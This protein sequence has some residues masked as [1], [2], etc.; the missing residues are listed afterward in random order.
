MMTW[1]AV[2][3]SGWDWD[4]ADGEAVIIEA[5]T[6]EGAA[7]NALQNGMAGDADGGDLKVAV[8]DLVGFVDFDR[9]DGAIAVGEF[10][11]INNTFD[12]SNDSD[13]IEPQ[14]GSIHHR[15]IA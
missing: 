4:S 11:P 12:D 10:R 14:D 2:Q 8:L 5:E 15:P 13:T 6:P 9:V 3:D 1:Y 7:K